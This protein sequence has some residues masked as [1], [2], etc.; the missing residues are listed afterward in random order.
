MPERMARLL[1]VAALAAAATAVSTGVSAQ[2]REE[3]TASFA[4]A[5]RNDDGYVDIDEF[6]AHVVTVFGGLDGD[7]DEHLQMS[8][9]PEVDSAAFAAID[10]DGDG[11]VSLGEAVGERVEVF[12][13]TDTDDDGRLSLEEVLAVEDSNN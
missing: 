3:L 9:V 12:F 6:V 11:R 5:D 10:S 2:T 8:D 4:E 13:E 7:R 1:A